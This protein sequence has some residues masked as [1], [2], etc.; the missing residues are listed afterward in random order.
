MKVTLYFKS[1]CSGIMTT[2]FNFKL[3][4]HSHTKHIQDILCKILSVNVRFEVL[5][6][7]TTK[8][9]G[10]WDVTPCSLAEI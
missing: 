9:A 2:N 3:Y 6:A 8:T 7:V 4:T 5:T 1:N 10:F